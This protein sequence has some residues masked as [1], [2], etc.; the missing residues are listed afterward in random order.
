MRKRS[1][2]RPRP[3]IV[4]PVAY[5]IESI[6]PV[7]QHGGYLLTLKI[8]NHESL[9]N[10]TQGKATK[11]DMNQ[12]LGMFNIAEA[13]YCMGIGREYGDVL[14]KAKDAL[15]EI[16]QRYYSINRFALT[17]PQMADLNL[18]ME[19]HD[20]QLDLCSVGDIEKA[21]NM[22]NERER[23]GNMTRIKRPPDAN[24]PSTAGDTRQS[25]QASP[26]QTT[27]NTQSSEQ[28]N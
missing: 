16:G 28:R 14:A 8:R 3:V 19:L 12:L 25:P 1:K 6:T 5:V 15:L 11:E 20:A 17:G 23:T 26:T 21:I 4:N 9:A 22:V 18:V 13:L 2:Y 27:A 7:A 24:T 10:L